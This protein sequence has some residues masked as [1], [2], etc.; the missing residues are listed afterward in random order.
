MN[1]M[2]TSETMAGALEIVTCF[3]TMVVAFVSYVLTWRG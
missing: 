1:S 2:I 3:F